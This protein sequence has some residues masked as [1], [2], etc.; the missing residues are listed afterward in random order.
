MKP[1]QHFKRRSWAGLAGLAFAAAFG[2]AAMMGAPEGAAQESGGKLETAIF[3][4]GCFW[5]MEAAFDEVRGVVE[6][7]SGYTGGHVDHPTY[8]DVTAE[9]SGHQESVRVRYDPQKV[10]YAQLLDAYWRNIDPF[11]AA[12]QFCDKGDSYR[13]VIFVSDETQRKLAEE[14]KQAVEKR[15]GR[16]VATRIRPASTFWPA[17]GYHQ[18]Y[19][20][21]NPLKYKFYK[22]NCGRAQRLEQVWGPP[23]QS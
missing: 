3:A 19:H 13:A 4:G 18:N 6:T 16:K 20:N 11:D 10:T 5:C 14:S 8:G 2:A 21:T 22:W 9:T 23:K 7:T 15:F 12:G 17:E 1:R